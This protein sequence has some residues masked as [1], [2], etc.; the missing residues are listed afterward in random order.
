VKKWDTK[1]S[2]IVEGEPVAV[3]PLHG[4]NIAHRTER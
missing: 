1:T 4:I 2:V 3:R